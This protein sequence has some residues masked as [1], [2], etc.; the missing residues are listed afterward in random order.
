MREAIPRPETVR[1]D[2]GAQSAT[3]LG[4]KITKKPTF[5]DNGIKSQDFVAKKEQVEKTYRFLNYDGK[6]LRFRCV[7]TNGSDMGLTGTGSYEGG[8]SAEYALH[9]YLSDDSVEVRNIKSR[10]MTL[11]DVNVLLRRGKL[12]KNWRDLPR[13]S[14]VEYVSASDLLCGATIDCYG[15]YLM[16]LDCDEPTREAFRQMGIEQVPVQLIRPNEVPVQ[17]AIPKLG[18]GFLPIGGEEATRTT[19]YNQPKTIK[20]WKKVYRNQGYLIRCRSKMIADDNIN[21]SRI[22]TVTFYLEDDSLSVFEDINRNSGMVGGNFL[23]RGKYLNGLPND[24]DVP[25]PFLATDIYLGNV[26]SVNGLEFQIFE[27]D[28]MSLDFCEGFPEEFPM[29]DVF[30]IV[31]GLLHKVVYYQLLELKGNHDLQVVSEGID[32]RA[33]LRASDTRNIGWINDE[34]FMRSLDDLGF[35]AKLNDQEIL[36]LMRKFKGEGDPQSRVRK[37][38]YYAELADLFSHIYLTTRSG[39]RQ[40]PQQDPFLQSLRI[41]TVQWRR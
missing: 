41:R 32:I 1:P 38:Y 29:F 24:S 28:E 40:R 6:V 37:Q 12:A 39:S 25:R 33:A 7:E 34:T 27:M 35:T 2:L 21:K 22:F 31:G 17:H 14:Q 20:N 3:G 16:L 19:V 23:K 13:G 18:D 10:K 26:I 4:A 36:S 30:N 5:T 11:D 8:N 9:F 15:R